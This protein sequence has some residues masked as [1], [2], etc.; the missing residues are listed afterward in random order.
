MAILSSQGPLA[1]GREVI[2]APAG[3]GGDSFSN[4]GNVHFRVKNGGAAPCVVTANCPNTDNFGVSGDS[5]DQSWT[6][7]AGKEWVLGPFNAARL[8]DGNGRVQITY[9]QVASVTVAVTAGTM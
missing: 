8:N 5:L 1:A 4:N 2:Y 7:P 9:D 6:V 3:A